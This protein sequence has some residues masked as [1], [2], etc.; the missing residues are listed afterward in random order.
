V[1]RRLAASREARF[2]KV[3]EAIP[4]DKR[5]AVLES[6]SLLSEVLNET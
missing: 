5:D 1:V 6:L 4:A 3:F 2:S